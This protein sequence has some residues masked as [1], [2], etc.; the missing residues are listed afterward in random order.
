MKDAGQ[1]QDKPL[2]GARPVLVD[3]ARKLAERQPEIRTASPVK[4]EGERYEVDLRTPGRV[5]DLNAD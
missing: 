3:A 2:S 1:Y 5:I 4:P